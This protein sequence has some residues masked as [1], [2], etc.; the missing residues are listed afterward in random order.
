[1]GAMKRKQG[2]RTPITSE[3]C[4]RAQKAVD[5][6]IAAGETQNQVAKSIGV[7]PPT[8]SEVIRG[9]GGSSIY[10]R[11]ISDGLGIRPPYEA[12]GD[13]EIAHLASSA[14]KL[15]DADPERYHRWR[16]RLF[17]ELEATENPDDE[18]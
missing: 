6:R 2:E 7:P 1:M 18:K 3:W 13:E 5:E 15:R 16:S 4:E 10:V 9:I 17:I 12:I 14:K 11:K 8:L